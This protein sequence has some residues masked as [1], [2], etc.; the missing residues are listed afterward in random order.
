MARKKRNQH[1]RN[2]KDNR[3]RK[4][5]TDGKDWVKRLL[6]PEDE[7]KETKGKRKKGSKDG[8]KRLRGDHF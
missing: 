6:D 4:S 7:E 2:R 8:A 5:M 1:L 3:K